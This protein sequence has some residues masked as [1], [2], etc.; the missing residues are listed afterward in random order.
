[1]TVYELDYFKMYW[2]WC[3]MSCFYNIKEALCQNVFSWFEVHDEFNY[4][5]C[6]LNNDNTTVQVAEFSIGFID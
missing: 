5:I 3:Q 1:M 4:R 6:D 2:I